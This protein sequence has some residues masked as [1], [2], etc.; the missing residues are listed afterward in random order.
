MSALELT[1]M[2]RIGELNAELTAC[3]AESDR[4]KSEVERL[5]KAGDDFVFCINQVIDAKP[6][7]RWTAPVRDSYMLLYVWRWNVA[8]DGKPSA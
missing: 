2:K 5:R 4:L 7:K 3:K 1:M 8:K 6:D